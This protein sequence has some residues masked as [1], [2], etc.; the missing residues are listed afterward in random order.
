MSTGFQPRE[1]SASR[2]MNEALTLSSNMRVTGI[3]VGERYPSRTFRRG[4]D[5][6]CFPYFSY[7]DFHAA[8]EISCV[9]IEDFFKD[10]RGDSEEKTRMSRLMMIIL[11]MLFSLAA[12]AETAK[13]VFIHAACDGT[14]SSVVFSS[15][16]DEIRASQ[17]YRLVRTLDDEGRMGIVLTVYMNCT[18]RND[19]IAVATSYGLAKC[20][21]EKNCHLSVDGHSIKS[22][23]C[24]TNASLE[25]GRVLFKA[26]DGYVHKPNPSTF[27]LN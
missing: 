15:L 5:D 8:R 7:R 27:K 21:G 16:R 18:E 11:L 24:D 9:R 17:K 12:E 4:R 1:H 6:S 26:F 3:V 14:I 25:C 10:S 2:V 19:V 23:L 22:T 20:Y 13:S